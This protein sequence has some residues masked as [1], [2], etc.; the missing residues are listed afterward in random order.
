M[1]GRWGFRLAVPTSP[2]SFCRDVICLILNLF[3][4]KT[5]RSSRSCDGSQL[6]ASNTATESFWRCLFVNL[7]PFLLSITVP[8]MSPGSPRRA[9]GRACGVSGTSLGSQG[10][11]RACQGG[12]GGVPGACPGVPGASPG[13]PGACPGD[14]GA[15]P[16][17]PG[18]CPADPW[19]SQGAPGTSRAFPGSF[20]QR[21]NFRNIIP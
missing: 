10:R 5:V 15:S 17:V 12:P 6:A 18:A 21:Y 2:K 13:V 11:A 9:Q 3:I 7:W 4:Q 20:S 8:W 19:D 14:P 16:A 1:T